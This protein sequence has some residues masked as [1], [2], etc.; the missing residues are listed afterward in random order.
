MLG[1]TCF[2]KPTTGTEADRPRGAELRMK[3]TSY[4]GHHE[5]MG[6]L[7]ML[8]PEGMVRGT[9][10]NRLPGEDRHG[11]EFWSTCKGLPWDVQPRRGEAA[12]AVDD[13]VGEGAAQLQRGLD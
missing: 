6:A 5:R 3:R 9:S 13:G 12:A 8:V 11:N 4:V 10:I 2:L 7:L 1:E